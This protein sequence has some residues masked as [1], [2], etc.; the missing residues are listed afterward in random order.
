MDICI[1]EDF[2]NSIEKPNIKTW[3]FIVNNYNICEQQAMLN[4]E[5]NNTNTK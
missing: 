2:H 1:K 3:R 5:F 4:H